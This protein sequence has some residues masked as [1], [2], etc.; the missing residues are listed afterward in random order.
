V[1]SLLHNPAAFTPE[2]ISSHN[3]LIGGWVSP[4][5]RLD[6]LEKIKIS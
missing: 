3:L 4:R 5:A 1:R 2:E 6:I